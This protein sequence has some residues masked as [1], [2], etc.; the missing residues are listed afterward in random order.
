MATR[1]SKPKDKIWNTST[2]EERARIREF[3]LSLGEDERKSLVKIEKEAVLRKM[4]EQQKHSCSCTVCGRKRTAIE[5]EL[6]VL[7]DAYYEELE[8]Y[9]NH[10]QDVGSILPPE[11]YAHATASMAQ[12]SFMQDHALPEDDYGDDPEGD[13]QDDFSQ[14]EDD[15]YDYSSEEPSLHPHETE[16]LQFGSSLQVKGGIL[17][18]ADDLLKNDG[19][20]F[21]EMMEQLAE[22][23]MQREEDAQYASHPGM[24]K[25]HTHSH[26]PPPEEDEYGDEED[27]DDGYDDDDYDEE[28]EDEDDVMTEEQRMEEGRRMFQIFAARMFEQRVLQAYREKVAAERQQRLLEELA[29]EDEK[30]DLKEAKKVKEAAKRKEKKDKQKQAKAEE[31]ARKDAEK[32]AQEAEAKAAEDKRLEEQRKKKD[33]QRKKKELERKA[34]DEEKQR[35]EAERIKRQQD[36]RERQQ[37]AERKAR[38]QKAV[39]KKAK[40]EA[41][42]KERDEREAREKEAREKKAQEDKER[43]ERDAKAKTERDRV[44]KEQQAA[45]VAQQ[46]AGVAKK[47]V[48]PIAPAL[49]PGLLKQSSSTGAPSPHVTPA[50]PKAPTPNRPRQSSRQGSHGSSPK[51]PYTALGAAKAMSPSSQAQNPIVPKSILTKPPTSQQPGPAHHAQPTSPMPHVG[52]PPGMG[53]LSTFPPGLNGFPHA[54]GPPMQGMMPS[55]PGPGP[56][57]SMFSPQQPGSQNF[58]GFHPPNVHSPNPMPMGRG[59]PMDHPPGFSTPLPNYGGPNQLPGYG[60]PIHSHSRQASGSDPIGSAPAPIGSAPAQPIARPTPIQRPSSVKPHEE[61]RRPTEVDELAD[62]L[63]SKAL[64]DDADDIPEPPPDRRTSLQGHGS[65]RGAPLAFPFPDAPGPHR[66]DVYAPFPSS[67]AGSVWGTPP[68]P[69]PMMG[70]TGWGNSPTSGPFNSPFSA[71]GGPR[72]GEMRIVWLRRLICNACKDVMAT[73]HTGPDVYIEASEVM[74]RVNAM[75]GPSELNISPQEVREAC[76]IFGEPHNGGGSL[77]VR[78]TAPQSGILAGVKFT[79]NIGPAPTLGEIGSPVPQPSVPVGGGFGGRPF[80]GLGSQY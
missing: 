71:T 49:P 33:E 54:Q 40:D 4:K 52:F 25:S 69:F 30:K 24:Y 50:I 56:S 27:E 17:T 60:M 34:Q 32:A 23:R 3:W 47:S 61:N 11:H 14:S 8:Q 39:E 16:F 58:R 67:S 63:G 10:R 22:R 38:E 20:K 12:R 1:G 55:R 68:M 41:K 6:E 26:G 18:V 2:D 62:H 5:E 65:M 46:V 36:E 9:A 37:E 21:I 73:R 79:E 74:D 70:S 29:E 59:Y 57:L 31:K 80:Q 66:P 28:E 19:K 75:Q 45:D 42:R 13:E 15:A 7:Y 44:R 76:E 64:L 43:R 51:M 53:P 78:D 72:P 77:D 35:K 48:Q